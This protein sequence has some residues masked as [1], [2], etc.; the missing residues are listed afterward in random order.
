MRP[1]KALKDMLYKRAYLLSNCD[2]TTTA[3]TQKHEGPS[4]SAHLSFAKPVSVEAN[5]FP[6]SE[7]EAEASSPHALA[8]VLVVLGEA[9]RDILGIHWHAQR[10][11]CRRLQKTALPRSG[12]NYFR[13]LRTLW[14][15]SSL[16][17][18][19]SA[20]RA[21]SDAVLCEMQLRGARCYLSPRRW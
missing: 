17:K 15:N 6:S 8:V 21:L 13:N 16:L 10:L 12:P 20:W 5:P 11:A 3:H 4:E 14:V 18:I 19:G 7:Y 1:S 9:G 2:C